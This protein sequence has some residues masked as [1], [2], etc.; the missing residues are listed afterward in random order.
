MQCPHFVE[1]MLA[2]VDAKMLAFEDVLCWLFICGNEIEDAQALGFIESDEVLNKFH[3]THSIY[4]PGKNE[5]QGDVS[6]SKTPKN[7]FLIFLQNPEN[8]V[9]IKIP[10]GFLCR[11]S[12]VSKSKEL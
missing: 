7:V 9:Q 10:I 3:R 11:I 8:L 2:I 5:R 4:K 12:E 6:A 1:V